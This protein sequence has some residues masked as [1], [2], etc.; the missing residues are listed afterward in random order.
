MTAGWVAGSVRAAALAQRRLTPRQL[1]ELA[2][3]PTARSAVARLATT[4]YG[5]DVVADHE[6]AQAQHAVGA[7]LLWHLRVLAGWVPRQGAH[8]LR[9]LAAGFEVANV[10][11]HLVRLGGGTVEP[12]YVLGALETA[13]AR[14]SRTR[15]PEQLRAALAASPW[16]DPG[17]PFAR[18]VH[19]VMTLTWAERVV[20]VVPSA[21]EW[22]RAAA[23][24]TVLREVLLGRQG[25]PPGRVVALT[26]RLL[27]PEFG[28]AVTGPAPSLPRAVER[29]PRG[30]RRMFGSVTEP[31]DL[32]RVELAWLHRLEEEGSALLRRSGYG[33]EHLV[34]TVALLTVDAWRARAALQAAALGE[35]PPA[36]PPAPSASEVFDALA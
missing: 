6:P 21:A 15:S 8:A 33:P 34:G 7:T 30:I 16:G 19:L 18:D 25:P 12:P 2:H 11:D 26:G 9:V 20:E 10:D 4:P 24:L 28:A 1:R 17:T 13:W 5:H 23:A 31:A 3:Q 35:L 27:G 22:A 32:W 14:V 29:L 36:A